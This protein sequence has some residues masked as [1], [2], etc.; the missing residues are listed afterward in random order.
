MVH[1][2]AEKSKYHRLGW[3]WHCEIAAAAFF[4]RH[5]A[6]SPG[7]AVVVMRCHAR[8][9]RCRDLAHAATRRM[10][11]S[12]SEVLATSLNTGCNDGQCAH[13]AAHNDNAVSH[14]TTMMDR[15]QVTLRSPGGPMV[16]HACGERYVMSLP[17][18]EPLAELLAR[19][20][21]RDQSAY[22]A[23]YRATA[24][25]LFGFALRILQRRDVAEECLQDA[26]VSIWHRAGDYRVRPRS[27]FHVDGRDRPQP[28]A[29]LFCAPRRRH[30]RSRRR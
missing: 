2:K 17:A 23:L 21:L 25:K 13:R 18:A 19:T 7:H 27:A 5:R 8:D 10:P 20:A 29:R 3:L 1:R 28:R 6:T 26:F 4:E 16:M 24:P 11:S 15:L 9:L 14:R 12:A 22:E 30:A